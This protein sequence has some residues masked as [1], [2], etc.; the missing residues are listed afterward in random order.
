MRSGIVVDEGGA[1]GEHGVVDRVPV[2][3]QLHGDLVHRSPPA[4]DLLGRPPPGPIRH[5]RPSRSDAQRFLGPGRDRAGAV[6]ATPSVLAPHQP[7]RAAEGRQVHK[8]NHRPVLDHPRSATA[9]ADRPLATGL[10]VNPQR[11]VHLVD[12]SEHRDLGK[13]DQQLA[14]ARRHPS[15]EDVKRLPPFLRSASRRWPRRRRPGWPG[16]RGECR[17]VGST[18]PAVP[19]RASC[20]RRAA[21]RK[22]GAHRAKR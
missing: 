11:S 20:R 19:R 4:T 16:S 6:G 21:R 9:G 10:D 1:E 22:S 14:H 3:A 7:R 8:G 18:G 15:V 12:D 5:H 2:A 13:S 17:R